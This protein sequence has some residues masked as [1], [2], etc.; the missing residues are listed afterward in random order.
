M[1][2]PKEVTRKEGYLFGKGPKCV[3]Y[4][5]KCDSCGAR[6]SSFKP[7][8]KRVNGSLVCDDGCLHFGKK[9]D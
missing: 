6:H 7:H 9:D 2:I 3:M 1:E 5:W 8:W 4:F